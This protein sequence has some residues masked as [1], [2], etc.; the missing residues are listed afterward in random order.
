MFPNSSMNKVKANS[1]VNSISNSIVHS[2]VTK[3]TVNCAEAHDHYISMP[4]GA[5]DPKS[6]ARGIEHSS[7][8]IITLHNEQVNKVNKESN[9]FTNKNT[10]RQIHTH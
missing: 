2:R 3:V 10:I 7:N 8:D 9:T 4:V 5:R 6:G 1:I